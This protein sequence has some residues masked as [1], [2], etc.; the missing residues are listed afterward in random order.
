MSLIILL[1]PQIQV[2]TISGFRFASGLTDRNEVRAPKH[3]PDLVEQSRDP[4]LGL[5]TA[6]LADRLRQAFDC[7]QGPFSHLKILAGA[8]E[9]LASGHQFLDQSGFGRKSPNHRFLSRS[10]APTAECYLPL[11]GASNSDDELPHEVVS[12]IVYSYL[13]LAT[14]ALGL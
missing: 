6:S 3:R 4:L 7:S 2:S 1:S 10:H 14:F 9:T 8:A 12:G 5:G 13:R 11:L